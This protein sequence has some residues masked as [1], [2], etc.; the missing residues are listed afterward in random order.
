MEKAKLNK[1]LIDHRI[2]KQVISRRLTIENNFK[3][4]YNARNQVDSDEDK[5]E[6]I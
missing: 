2:L 5:K 1:N 6:T 3:T 4:F